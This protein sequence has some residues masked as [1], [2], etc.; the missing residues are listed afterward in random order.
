MQ[1][2]MASLTKEEFEMEDEFGTLA[3]LQAPLPK[4]IAKRLDKILVERIALKC[5]G[6][7]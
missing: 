4:Y 3:K 5:R 6:F 7:L 1:T 2:S